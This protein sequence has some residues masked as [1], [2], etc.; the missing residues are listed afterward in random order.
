LQPTAVGVSASSALGL[1][2]A[3]NS[4]TSSSINASVSS[5]FIPFES[6]GNTGHAD[7]AGESTNSD[8]FVQNV[9]NGLSI[10]ARSNDLGP[11]NNNPSLVSSVLGSPADH[12]VWINDE[13]VATSSFDPPCFLG[14]RG[15]VQVQPSTE[16]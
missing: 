9:H 3:V 4:G 1:L 8:L 16:R 14:R 6:S 5:E 12:P 10:N 13:E 15:K 7:T 11:S 2:P